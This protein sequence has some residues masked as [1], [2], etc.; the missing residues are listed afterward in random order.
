MRSGFTSTVWYPI[1]T[2][3]VR[4]QAED[5][6]LERIQLPKSQHILSFFARIGGIFRVRVLGD[7]LVASPVL[8]S[9]HS[10]KST[11]RSRPLTELLW[12]IWEANGFASA[13]LANA[14]INRGRFR[15]VLSLLLPSPWFT[16]FLVFDREE[17]LDYEGP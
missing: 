6:R 14:A 12:P 15:Q 8:E 2:P 9:Q 13:F 4:S 10:C 16:P 5:L 7:F 11:G 17:L 1:L 3:N